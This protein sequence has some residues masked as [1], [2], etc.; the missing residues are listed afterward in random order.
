MRH[1]CERC[2]CASWKHALCYTH[3]REAQG[4]VFDALRKVFVKTK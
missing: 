2:K 1:T 3:F 4:F